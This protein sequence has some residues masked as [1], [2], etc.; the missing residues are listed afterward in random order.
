MIPELDPKLIH[1][2]RNKVHDNNDFVRI[3]FVDYKNSYGTEG[4]DIWSKICSCMDWLTVAV[5]GIEKPRYDRNMNKTS[6]EFTHFIVTIDMIVEAV[7]HLWLSIGQPTRDKQPYINDC[8]IFKKR[9]FDRD[10]TDEK[11]VKE[12]RSWFGIHS[13]NGNE[14]ELK[15]F[16][17]KVRFF[18]S[19]STSHDGQEFS[20]RLY[21]NNRK[22]EEEYGGSKK[23]TVD[24]L[25]KFV[26]LRYS[27]LEKLIDKIDELYCRVKKELQS[28]PVHL[29][30]S[31]SD[32]MQLKEL[33]AQAKER[34]LTEEHY[35][36]DIIRYMSFLEC[37]LSLFEKVERRIV[38][39]YLSE[40]KTI[41][42]TYRH[43]IQQVDHNEFGVFKML[44]MNSQ[45]YADNS[46][47]YGKALEYA[48]QDMFNYR[49]NISNAFSLDLLIEKQLL[50]KYSRTL[51]GNYLSLLI[52]A[53]DYEN[54]KTYPRIRNQNEVPVIIIDDIDEIDVEVLFQPNEK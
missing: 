41:I 7:N 54:N 25:L 47:D 35:E 21:S 36:G 17:K 32:L 14:I 51:P 15:G 3:F 8:S 9:E 40:L 37:D 33:Y 30:E 13:V 20:L 24:S 39:D 27:T 46:Y 2:F 31:S 5:E 53:L 23:I 16:E 19:W 49:S 1:R 38:T 50:P 4:I 45:I 12:I 10:Y 34:K 22:A 6:L 48:E 26:A 18:S 28:T 11:Y 29:D 42:P 44:G 52:H 43:I